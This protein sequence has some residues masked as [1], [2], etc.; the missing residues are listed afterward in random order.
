MH[1]ITKGHTPYT[2]E[3]LVATPS[4]NLICKSLPFLDY[5]LSNAT[6][7][8]HLHQVKI[9][10]FPLSFPPLVARSF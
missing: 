2:G 3:D 6:L 9:L 4:G 8:R 5:F 7:K 10:A 1:Q